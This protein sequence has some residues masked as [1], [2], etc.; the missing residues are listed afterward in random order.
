MTHTYDAVIA[1]FEDYRVADDA[2]GKLIDSGFD[3]K[4]FSVIGKS[5]SAE[6]KL[7]GL[8]NAGDRIKFWGKYGAFW[9]GLWG[10]FLGGVF[11]S[12]P[13]VGPV[14]VVGQLAE[15]VVSA[16]EGAL[17]VGGLSVLGAA[18]YHLGIPRDS[19]IKYELAINANEFLMVTHG[20]EEQI[21]RARAILAAAFPAQLDTYHAISI[22]EADRSYATA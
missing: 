17:V 16:I 9:G 21:Q 18:L 13:M 14:V 7:V 10:L 11:L 5:H 19:V 22:V 8:Y 2:I 1:V 6:D 20:T 4:N 15:M 12:I 3:M